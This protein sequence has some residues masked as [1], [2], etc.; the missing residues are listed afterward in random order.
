M[1]PHGGAGV[2]GQ[3]FARFLFFFF[4]FYSLFFA[5]FRNDFLSSLFFSFLFYFSSHHFVFGFVLSVGR[6]FSRR[7]HSSPRRRRRRT[8][9]A[10][11]FV[12]VFFS[13]R[14]FLLFSFSFAI[15]ST[16][17]SARWPWCTFFFFFLL[18]TEF[19]RVT[20]VFYLFFLCNLPSAPSGWS[21]LPS[22]TGFL[23]SF[24]EFYRVLP[25]LTRVFCESFA[26]MSRFCFVFTSNFICRRLCFV[27]QRNVPSFYRL[28]R[29]LLG[30]FT[31]FYCRFQRPE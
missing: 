17:T 24:T 16:E 2:T 26:A 13:S 6:S 25:S 19:Y 20:L 22:F 23:P 7:R 9:R 4:F 18:C 3:T 29:S 21:P 31:E 12:F 1:T 28:E 27:S 11:S 10:P 30:F 14:W 5:L 15:D 8:A